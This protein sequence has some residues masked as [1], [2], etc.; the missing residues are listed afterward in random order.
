MASNQAVR[1]EVDRLRREKVAHQ[2]TLERLSAKST[3]MDEDIVFL[4]QA[5]HDALDQREKV[6]SKFMALQRDVNWERKEKLSHREM[7]SA[8]RE[9]S[10][11]CEW[12]LLVR[13]GGCASPRA[14][15]S[16]RGVVTVAGAVT[17]MLDARALMKRHVDVSPTLRG[18]ECE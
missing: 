3:K 6:K 10:L 17:A 5:A 7:P 15:T 16:A 14:R 18:C 1:R 11:R 4:T 2:R 9:P 8:S 13:E 12:M